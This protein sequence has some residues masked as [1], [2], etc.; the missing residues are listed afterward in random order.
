MRDVS[1]DPKIKELVGQIDALPSV[2]IIYVE[3]LE[4]LKM[5]NTSFKTVADIVGKDIAMT[6]KILQLV[7]S[8]FFGFYRNINSVEHAVGILGMRMIRSLVLSVKVFQEYSTEKMAAFPIDALMQHSVATG[9]LARIIA[10]SQS[11]DA[12]FADD[13]FM[14]GMLHDVGKLVLADKI[15]DRYVH[16]RNISKEQGIPFHQAETNELGITHGEVGAYLMSQWGIAESVVDA[17]SFHHSPMDNPNRAFSVL[18]VIHV[19]NVMEHKEGSG[20]ADGAGPEV[21]M[22]YL[23][24]LGMQGRMDKWSEICHVLAR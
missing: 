22:K 18:T 14:A 3:L 5:S 1:K 9:A 19:A 16:V 15:I 11:K 23:T 13:C 20:A 7:N 8:A 21:D 2:P 17:I 12:A 10:K 4:S 24:A 6:A